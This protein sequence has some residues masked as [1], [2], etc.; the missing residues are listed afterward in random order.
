MSVY[1]YMIIWLIMIKSCL[2]LFPEKIWIEVQD[3]Y[4]F[5]N[6][7]KCDFLNVI[8]RLAYEGISGISFCDMKWRYASSFL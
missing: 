6:V 5:F 3:L 2:I 1:C 4:V 7:L 8:F